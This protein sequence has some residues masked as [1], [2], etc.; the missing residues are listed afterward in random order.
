MLA[1][2]YIYNRWSKSEIKC[3]VNGQLASATEMSWLVSTNDPFDKCYIGASPELDEEHLFSGQMSAVY[4]FSEALSTH[5]VC[6]IH[7]LG[8]GYQAQFRFEGESPTLSESLRRVLYDGKLAQ[9]MLFCYNPVATDS[10]L[11]LQAAPKT[12]GGVSGGAAFFVHN[13]H[14][15]M[16]QE[17]RAVT[18]HGIHST[19]NSIGGLQMLFPLL[20]QLDYPVQGVEH[21]V[22]T[23]KANGIWY[24]WVVVNVFFFQSH[25][26]VSFYNSV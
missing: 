6:G 11:C 15:L 1:V 23:A 2:V 3:F 17:V 24:V 20:G 9:A 8:P 10:Q 16:L 22:N 26:H 7:R 21:D 18:T 13:P 19:L 5:Q 14:A 25:K 4:L 12:P